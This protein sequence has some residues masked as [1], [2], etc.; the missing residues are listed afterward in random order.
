MYKNVIFDFYGTL[1][2]ISTNENKRSLWKAMAQFFS[3]NGA[4]YSPAE[5]KKSYF[6]SVKALYDTS[7][8]EH[9]DVDLAVV[10]EKLYTDKDIVPSQECVR[11]TAQAFRILSTDY[12]RMYGGV[13]E[14]LD[15]L[16]MRGKKVYL[17]TN[18]QR[19]FTVPE[20]E[21]L[22]IY[23][24]FDGIVISSDVKCCKP[25]KNIFKALTDGFSLKPE[26]CVMIGNDAYADIAGA[27]GAGMD[28]VYVKSNLSPD[29]EPEYARYTTDTAHLADILKIV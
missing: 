24:K 19:L 18:A 22:G 21:L 14:L 7:P 2:D 10:F 1:A 28:A 23:E 11:L 17:L 9:P 15:A 20:L 13:T 29:I 27:Y 6:G 16:H 3:F 12:L 26:E 5:L 25:D 8:F 4:V